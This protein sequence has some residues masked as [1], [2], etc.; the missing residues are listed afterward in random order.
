M[1]LHL[2]LRRRQEWVLGIGVHHDVGMDDGTQSPADGA[3]LSLGETPQCDSP[4]GLLPGFV[5][6]CDLLWGLLLGERPRRRVFCTICAKRR[7]QAKG[8]AFKGFC[9]APECFRLRECNERCGQS[10][11]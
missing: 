8:R 1:L 10:C 3:E 11:G 7:F 9:L 4:Q 6:H 5:G 2:E